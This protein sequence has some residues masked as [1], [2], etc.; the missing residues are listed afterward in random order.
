MRLFIAI[1]AT[2]IVA[3]AVDGARSPAQ[4]DPYRWCAQYSGRGATN[5][6]FVTLEQ[7]QWALSGNGGFCVPNTFYDGRPVVTPEYGGRPVGRRAR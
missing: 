6:G 1:A 5:C 3:S 7:C 2:L 4:A